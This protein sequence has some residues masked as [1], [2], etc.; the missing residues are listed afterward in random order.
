M[1][2]DRIII[3]AIILFY[4][5]DSLNFIRRHYLIKKNEAF[6]DRFVEEKLS[7]NQEI[8]NEHM[9]LAPQILSETFKPTLLEEITIKICR[10][11]QPYASFIGVVWA[12]IF[13]ETI[14]CLYFNLLLCSLALVTR[15]IKKRF[16]ARAKKFRL[17]VKDFSNKILTRLRKQMF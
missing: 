10:I 5:I 9:M 11:A 13:L 7:D 4:G 14:Y 12:V 8:K 2:V 3:L 1:L 17:R 6:M 16:Y 15:E